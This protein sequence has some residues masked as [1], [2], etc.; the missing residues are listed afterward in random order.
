MT[1][2]LNDSINDMPHVELTAFL[3]FFTF[4]LF[5]SQ[6]KLLYC[7]IYE[8]SFLNVDFNSHL[9]IKRY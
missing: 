4:T 9:S 3:K 6:K 2:I 8:D 1:D 7:N 5:N